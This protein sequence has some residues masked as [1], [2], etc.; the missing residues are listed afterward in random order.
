MAVCRTRHC[1]DGGQFA[2][3]YSGLH[4]HWSGRG[5]IGHF[6][7]CHHF[8]F[9][10][11]QCGRGCLYWCGREYISFCETGT[12]GLLNG[13]T[14]IRHFVCAENCYGHHLRRFGHYIPRPYPVF[15]R[16][17]RKYHQLC[18]RLYVGDTLGQCVHTSVLRHERPAA[19]CRK[20]QTCDVCHTLHRG[21]EHRSRPVVH[22]H[23][24]HG[25]PRCGYRHHSRTVHSYVLAAVVV[26]QTQ[27]TDTFPQRHIRFGQKYHPKHTGY[28]HLSLLNERLRL[29]HR[30]THQYGS[31]ALWR[32]PGGGCLRHCQP[33]W[34][35]VLYDCDGH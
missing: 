27:G 1:G 28:R 11:P 24:P 18:P 23:L 16:R 15:L 5:C 29:Y 7:S 31:G 14:D 20:T 9:H 33:H 32:R 12:E 10:E 30:D 6:R 4:L 21:L 3:Q 35:P 8:S 25:H 22:L 13:A 17:N 34:V 26:Q 2:V 19:R